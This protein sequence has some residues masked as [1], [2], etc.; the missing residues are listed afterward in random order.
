[1][2]ESLQAATDPKCRRM[3]ISISHVPTKIRIGSHLLC[4]S[5]LRI[6]TGQVSEIHSIIQ[7]GMHLLT[8]SLGNPLITKQVVDE[9]PFYRAE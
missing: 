7:K 5:T 8:E 9:I 3:I 2:S 1:M 4:V 6:L